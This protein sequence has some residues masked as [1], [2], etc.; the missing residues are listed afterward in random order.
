MGIFVSA[1]QEDSPA[2][3]HSIKPGDR[4]LSI[5]DKSMV[6]IT[7]EEVYLLLFFIVIVI[8]F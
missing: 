4:I 2:A 7:R 3:Q 1:V 8:C 6:G 5:N